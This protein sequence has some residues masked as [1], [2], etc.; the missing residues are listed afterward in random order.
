MPAA[1][2]SP[3]NDKPVADLPLI[4]LHPVADCHHAWSALL[5][6]VPFDRT[7]LSRLFGELGLFDALGPLPC[8]VRVPD[9]ADCL[10]DAAEL[11]PAEQ[12]LLCL[13][14]V[15]CADPRRADELIELRRQGFRLMAEGLSAGSTLPGDAVQSVALPCPAGPLPAEAAAWLSGRP[16]PH[17]ALGVDSSVAFSRCRDAG[18]RWF[19]GNYPLCQDAGRPPSGTTHQALLLRLLGLIALDADA[20]ALEEIFKQDAHLSY[21]LLRLVNSVAFSLSSKIAS[22]SQAITLLGRRQL[23]RWLQ[24]LIYAR[25]PGADT[26]PLMPRAALRAELMQT[27]CARL[28]GNGDLQDKAFMV[29]M[30]SLL[31]HLLHMSTADI[32]SPLNLAEDV[33]GALLERRGILGR[34]LAVVEISEAGNGPELAAALAADGLDAADWSGALIESYHWAIRVSQEA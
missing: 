26:N 34:L 33:I 27:L 32:I 5:L 13:P 7:L 23:Q 3:M 4:T 21:Q 14:G 29:G 9:P 20:H 30:F 16:G 11:L 8:I 10:S 28:G 24:L 22:F 19:A 15:L 1:E 31:G 6:D 2:S 25:S 12:M 18:F 17:L